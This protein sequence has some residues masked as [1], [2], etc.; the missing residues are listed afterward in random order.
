M[1][2]QRSYQ[3]RITLDFY[4]FREK[5]TKPTVNKVVPVAPLITYPKIHLLIFSIQYL[6]YSISH[7]FFVL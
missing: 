3:A 5:P 1:K 7:S 2:G 6:H 4:R